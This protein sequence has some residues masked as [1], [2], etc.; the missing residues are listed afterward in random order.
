MSGSSALFRIVVV[1]VSNYVIPEK[2]NLTLVPTAA[3]P[4]MDQHAFVDHLFRRYRGSLSRYLIQWRCTPEE[5]EEI[6]QEAYTRILQ[7]P[8]LEHLESKARGYLFQTAT[9]LLRD[10]HRYDMARHRDQHEAFDEATT[11]TP[12]QTTEGQ[13]QLDQEINIIKAA[14]LQ[15]QP[16]CREVFLLYFVEHLKQKEIAR[17]MG[18]S[19]KT[20]ERDL[21]LALRYCKDQLGVR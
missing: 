14:L 6:L 8:K 21:T 16:R 2:P 5:A 20:V 11:E 3:G 10:R 19:T 9:N 7:A 4:S 17:I 15:L 1:E 13:V 12:D 18:V